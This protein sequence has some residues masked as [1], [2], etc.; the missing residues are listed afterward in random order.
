MKEGKPTIF[1]IDRVSKP[2][3]R[4]YSKAQEIK[5]VLNGLGIAIVST[6][7]GVMTDKQAREA[8]VGGEVLCNV[9]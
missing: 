8:N 6:S 2:S 1:G 7:K 5:P 9:W 4:V 3:C